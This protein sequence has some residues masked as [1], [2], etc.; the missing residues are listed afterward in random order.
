ME[1]QDSVCYINKISTIVPIEGADKIEL[2]TINGWTSIV[3]KGIHK[4]GDTIM[5]IVTD[6]VIPEHHAEKWGV[7]QYLRKGG[8][9]RTIKL[10]GVYSECILIPVSE[11]PLKLSESLSNFFEGRDMMDRFEI[12][13]Y[14]EPENTHTGLGNGQ[15]RTSKNRLNQNFEKYHKF[16]NY[17]NVPNIFEEGD[18]VCITRKIHGCNARYAI[19]KKEPSLWGKIKKFFGSKDMKIDYEYVYGSHNVQKIAGVDGYYKSDVWAQVAE[20]NAMELTL[21]SIAEALL[22]EGKL[23]KGIT[24]YGEVFGPG[25]QGKDYHY[26]ETEL[27]FR[28]FDIQLDGQYLSR[29]EFERINPF[30]EATVLYKG[31]WSKEI[32][33]SYVLNQYIGNS[34]V[35]HEGVVVSCLTGDRRKIAKVINP[36]YHTY[37]E[38]HHVPDSH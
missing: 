11:I 2:A 6:A 1:N 23:G 29:S 18:Q 36:E 35:P 3:Q 28:S 13:K 33:D 26:D 34:K 25:I 19:L 32:Q 31:P 24:L 38:K 22:R 17:K 37:A 16:P 9:V 7:K 27:S 4:E 5:C 8:R 20:K 15:P 12:Y 10:K 30:A 21:W 14:E